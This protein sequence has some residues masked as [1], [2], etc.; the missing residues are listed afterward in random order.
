MIH[1]SQPMEKYN[2]PKILQRSRG[3]NKGGEHSDCP[4]L[5]ANSFEHNNHVVVHSTMP[6][7]GDPKK[8]GTGPLK[9]VNEAYCLDAHNSMVIQ[10][11][12]STESGGKQPYQQNR[13]YD[14]DG[15]IPA[16][17]AQLTSGS[18]AIKLG[19]HQQDTVH[20]ENGIMSCLAVGSHGNSA[21]LTKTKIGQSIRR[22]TP[23]EC[24]R[25][26]G[27]PDTWLKYGNYDGEIKVISDS[28]QYKM[29]GNGVSIPP[30]R[31]IGKKILTCA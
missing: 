13:V 20:D 15:V 11:N 10:V 25:L 17:Q 30:V 22:L 23:T 16:L 27:L 9:K 3:N 6:R 14:A 26:Q 12:P 1:R 31:E 7:T 29:A 28:Q 21:H 24:A 5:S 2:V 19:K 8:E 18:H 4:T